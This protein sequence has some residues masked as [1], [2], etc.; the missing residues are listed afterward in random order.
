MTQNSGEL[1]RL[2]WWVGNPAKLLGFPPWHSP[3]SLQTYPLQEWYLFKDT[4]LKMSSSRNYWR[5][6]RSFSERSKRRI[7]FRTVLLQHSWPF[8]CSRLVYLWPPSYETGESTYGRTGEDHPK[9]RRQTKAGRGHKVEGGRCLKEEGM[10][11]CWAPKRSSRI[12]TA[13]NHWIQKLGSSGK[14]ILWTSSKY[15]WEKFKNP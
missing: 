3:L 10:V 9:A 11:Q 15:C 12:E 14:N 5:K 1:N 13:R 8:N 4:F 2:R 7:P 6:G